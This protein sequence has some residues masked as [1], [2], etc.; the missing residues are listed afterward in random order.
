MAARGTAQLPSF[1]TD[2][3]LSVL[4]KY[5]EGVTKGKENNLPSAR[6]GAAATKPPPAPPHGRRR[7]ALSYGVRDERAL[8][9]RIGD[10]FYSLGDKLD[11]L[12]QQFR[13]MDEDLSGSL[14]TRELRNG[15]E[16]FNFGLSDSEI[17]GVVGTL[18]HNEDGTVDY[19]EFIDFFAS[20]QPLQPN[21][22][23]EQARRTDNVLTGAPW[24]PVSSRFEALL[25]SRK[26]AEL[27]PA[28]G[29]K[30][31]YAEGSYEERRADQLITRVIVRKFEQAG[32]RIRHAFRAMDADRSGSLSYREFALGIDK[33]GL[34]LEPKHIRRLCQ[35]VD[36]DGS[37]NIDYEEFMKTFE[38]SEVVE[39][40]FESVLPRRTAEQER[41]AAEQR[42]ERVRRV[43][44]TRA[45]RMLGERIYRSSKNLRSAFSRIDLNGDGQL[46][47]KELCDGLR[48][49]CPELVEQEIK[50]VVEAV[51]ASGD[52][53]LDYREFMSGLEEL[54]N[55]AQ[56]SS[57]TTRTANPV[58]QVPPSA[59]MPIPGHELMSAHDVGVWTSDKGDPRPQRGRIAGGNARGGVHSALRPSSAA[60]AGDKP[61]PPPLDVSGSR[62]VSPAHSR[63]RSADT[64]RTVRG[65]RGRY[66]S[67]PVQRSTYASLFP[68]PGTPA[69]G[70]PQVRR[71]ATRDEVFSVQQAR[72]RALARSRAEA[73]M[74]RIRQHASEIDAR[75]TA[76]DDFLAHRD[77][78]KLETKAAAKRAYLERLKLYEMRS[79][80]PSATGKDRTGTCTFFTSNG[81]P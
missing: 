26:R 76:H 79:S 64:V 5:P 18:D 38:K 16:Q 68:A 51:D 48:T 41:I 60:M 70:G 13:N 69:Y 80:D 58:L 61:W 28:L 54:S 21:L 27:A 20:Y 57:A 15:L 50:E 44:N 11:R 77:S 36:N 81:G 45:V 43:G 23:E 74:S 3:T 73:R 17:D 62:G 31:V 22:R 52:G 67:T 40:E 46:S 30:P 25:A 1:L 71:P 63:S 8:L 12:R 6:R 59:T 39:M 4:D 29:A 19:E 10:K 24:E 53:Y 42:A 2:T 65:G 14:D 66:A 37:G 72:E 33:L 78:A 32:P 56:L 34:G 35:M 9:K 49:M 55:A 7:K 75:R 47:H